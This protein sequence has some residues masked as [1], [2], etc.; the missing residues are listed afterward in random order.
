MDEEGRPKTYVSTF[1]LALKPQ[2]R[3]LCV[4]RQ[5]EDGLETTNNKLG[6][7]S[8]T[9]KDLKNRRKIDLQAFKFDFL[10]FKLLNIVVFITFTTITLHHEPPATAAPAGASCFNMNSKGLARKP[11]ILESV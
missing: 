11:G 4:K 6:V 10:F 3:P 1:R 9:G 5:K 7:S 8:A 2:A